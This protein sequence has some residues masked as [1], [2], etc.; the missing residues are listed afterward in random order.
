PRDR[1]GASA[2]SSPQ[3][4]RR[5]RPAAAPGRAPSRSPA[6][7]RRAGAHRR[8]S[9]RARAPAARDPQRATPRARAFAGTAGQGERRVNLRVV[10]ALTGLLVALVALMMLAPLGVALYDGTWRAALGYGA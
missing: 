4:N 1:G 8:R 10:A 9:R 5:P 7:P 6:R 3:A 2:P